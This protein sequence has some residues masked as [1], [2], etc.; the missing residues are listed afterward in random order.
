MIPFEQ[1]Q[2]PFIRRQRPHL[3]PSLLSH[4]VQSP[5]G[6]KIH[7]M[8]TLSRILA[9]FVHRRPGYVRVEMH[10]RLH[11]ALLSA[12]GEPEVS[13]TNCDIKGMTNHLAIVAPALRSWDWHISQRGLV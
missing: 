7:L 3:Y 6:C 8:P 2:A 5:V 12:S 1:R 4:K 13:A 11:C 9:A 10:P